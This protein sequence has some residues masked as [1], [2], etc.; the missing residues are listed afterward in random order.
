MRDLESNRPPLK[1]AQIKEPVSMR[2]PAFFLRFCRELR[3]ISQ[4][5]FDHSEEEI[6]KL[7]LITNVIREYR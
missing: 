7:C 5:K 1:Q 2:R 3:G 4:N 6:E